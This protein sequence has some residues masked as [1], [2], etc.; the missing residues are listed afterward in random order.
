MDL[1]DVDTWASD[2]QIDELNTKLFGAVTDPSTRTQ[3][4]RK[5]SHLDINVTEKKEKKRRD[6][7]GSSKTINNGEESKVRKKRKNKEN[8]V[9]KKANQSSEINRKV[10]KPKGLKAA[11]AKVEVI[12]T[13]F[14]GNESTS[15]TDFLNAEPGG[16]GKGKGVLKKKRRRSSKKNKYKHL[17]EFRK[18]LQEEANEINANKS[19]VDIDLYAKLNSQV[20]V[21]HKTDKYQGNKN[22]ENGNVASPSRTK[23][24]S[25]KKKAKHPQKKIE[26]VD[27]M[28]NEKESFRSENTDHSKRKKRLKKRKQDSSNVDDLV[29]PPKKKKS[30]TTEDSN[31]EIIRSMPKERKKRNQDGP[32]VDDLV[33]PS[34]KKKSR[35]T[36]DSNKEI[37]RSMPKE[38]KKRNQD[39]PDV[40]DLVDPPK[41]KKSRTAEDSNKEII[42]S[43]PKQEIAKKSTLNVSHLG[44]AL[45]QQSPKNENEPNTKA[46]EI[47]KAKK[48][49]SL[50]LR[51]RMLEQLNSSRFR[52]INE[53]LYSVPGHEVSIIGFFCKIILVNNHAVS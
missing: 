26:N 35:T 29:D 25:K 30:R 49:K 4:K 9:M 27:T 7:K 3:S 48:N 19:K 17:N 10:K 40:D 50:S 42:R 14:E 44:E 8:S 33:D 20:L 36:E 51:D 32:D 43:M 12:E 31:K 18:S 6:N 15:F 28:D 46:K 1:F 47:G 39:G 2:K 41:K 5:G 11:S 53:Q 45:K 23:N 38:R 22:Y 24:K 52:Y 34:R 16:H 13:Q 37:I 21:P